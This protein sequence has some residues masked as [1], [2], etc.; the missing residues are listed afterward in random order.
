MKKM[1]R[2]ALL[3]AI[4]SVSV[5]LFAQQAPPAGAS[6]QGGQ[7]GAPPAD[8]R[9]DDMT[10]AANLTPE[11][12]TKVEAIL[13][14]TSESIADSRSKTSNTWNSDAMAQMNAI[15]VVEE[16]AILAVLN[17]SQKPKYEAYFTAWKAERAKDKH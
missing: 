4:A 10:K 17:E 8:T 11:Q 9:L 5:T 1:I 15:F 14:K 13:K 16:K 7:S 6:P 12:R 3:C 2:V